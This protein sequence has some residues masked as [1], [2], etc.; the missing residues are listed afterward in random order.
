MKSCEQVLTKGHNLSKVLFLFA[1]YDPTTN[2]VFSKRVALPHH[3]LL[4]VVCFSFVFISIYRRHI[5]FNL[6]CTGLLGTWDHDI[7][8]S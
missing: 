6:R 8:Q 3:V 1:L 7:L 5:M 4:I 2:M